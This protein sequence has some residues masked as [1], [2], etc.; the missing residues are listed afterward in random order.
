M[1][2][3]AAANAKMFPAKTAVVFED[4]RYTWAEWNARIN[5]LAHALRAL[6]LGRGDK[7]AVMLHNCHQFLEVSQATSKIGVVIVPLNY[8]LRGREIEYIVNNADARAL[9]CG[10]EFVPEITPIMSVLPG[11]VPGG[12]IVVGARTRDARFMDYDR[13]LEAQPTSEPE[14]QAPPGL[15]AMIYTSG[16]TGRPKGVYR[17]GG[18]DSQLILAIVQGFGL[19]MGGE[20]HIVPAPLYHSAPTLG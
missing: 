2:I 9:V 3:G 20:V 11:I 7:L 8:R 10:E 15:N 18:I 4:V 1:E 6:G 12:Y 17:P 16:T 5:Q 19:Q 14:A 13:L